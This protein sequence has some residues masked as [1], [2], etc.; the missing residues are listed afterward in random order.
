[1]IPLIIWKNSHWLLWMYTIKGGRFLLIKDLPCNWTSFIIASN[2]SGHSAQKQEEPN[3]WG[4]FLLENIVLA[5]PESCASSSLFSWSGKVLEIKHFQWKPLQSTQLTGWRMWSWKYIVLNEKL[6]VCSKQYEWLWLWLCLWLWLWSLK[7]AV[8][9]MQC[10]EFTIT[11][12]ALL[13]W[14]GQCGVL[15]LWLRVGS[16]SN[17]EQLLVLRAL[18]VGWQVHQSTSHALTIHDSRGG[19]VSICH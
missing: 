2:S 1:M 3:F 17:P 4:A 5:D 15:Q 12:E 8:C 9:N 13:L 10:E 19:G 7:C 6:K 16:S 18:R 11:V 14:S